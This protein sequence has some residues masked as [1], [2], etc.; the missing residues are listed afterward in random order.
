[1][2]PLSISG[3]KNDIRS[4]LHSLGRNP[5]GATKGLTIAQMRAMQ[6][7]LRHQQLERD[8]L[9]IEEE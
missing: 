7:E 3:L 8:L 1:M 6:A 4:L 5:K 9:K 2:P